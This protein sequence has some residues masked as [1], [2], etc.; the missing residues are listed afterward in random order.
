MQPTAKIAAPIA[1]G[2]VGFL[3]GF[4]IMAF[5][6]APWFF[7]WSALGVAIF[8][9]WLL[10]GIGI[11]LGYHRLLSH[12][13][14]KVPKLMEYGIAILGALALQGGPI[15]W[16]G[17]H[18]QHHAF[19]DQ[20]NLDP[21]SAERGFW[22]SHMLWMVYPRPGFFSANVYA[23]YAPDLLRDPVYRWLDRYYLYLQLPL[24]V[25]LYLFGGWSFVVYGIFVR[26]VLLWHSTWL[27]NS[28]THLWG[29]QT[30]PG[31]GNSRNNWVVAL[32]TYGEGW[33]NHH[34]AYPQAAKNGWNWWEFDTTW[35]T[36][37]LLGWLGLA[38]DIKLPPQ[39]N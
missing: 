27:V 26:S 37:R 20:P 10:G 22:W 13:S 33:H 7:S 34:H 24:A 8:L 4:H 3:G 12:K 31:K 36:I 15:F 18:R 25:V 16:V 1:W 6:L 2:T 38:K 5:M 32:L 14:F 17:W 11:C 39:Q 19:E 35:E 23:K 30:F 28:A 9:H 29:Y 21:Y